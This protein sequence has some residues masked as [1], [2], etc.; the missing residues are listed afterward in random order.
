MDDPNRLDAL[1]REA[2]AHLVQG[3]ADLA[4]DRISELTRALPDN[5]RVQQLARKAA[6]IGFEFPARREPLAVE[7]REPPAQADVDLVAFHVGLPANPSGIHAEIDY[8]A[9]LSRS[10]EAARLRAPEARRILITD[11]ATSV[12]DSIG[13]NAVVRFPIDTSKL[14]FERMRVQERFLAARPAGRASVLMDSDVVVNRD[15]REVF[16]EVFDVGLTWRKGFVEAPF[17]GGM[18]FVAEG[19]AGA[20]F[21]RRAI[22]CYEAI[23]ADPGVR[24]A[25][26]QGIK[27]WWGDQFAL[28]SL[29]GYRTWAESTR[30]ALRIDDWRVRFLPCDEYNATLEAGRPYTPQELRA[31]RF[32]HFKGNRKDQQS[33]YL[34]LMRAGKL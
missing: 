24:A 15:P 7:R 21:F 1:Y 14:M 3:R 34:D 29:V 12:P 25:F 13:A 30:E 6:V 17:N 31:K 16:G 10:F 22:E 11:E 33:Q 19:D 9:V 4:Q 18:L 26:P 23:A 20:A 5:E 28:A 27:A 2:G 8:M 32:I